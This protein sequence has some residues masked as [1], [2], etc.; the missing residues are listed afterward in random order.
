MIL[1][2]KP[3]FAHLFQ[4]VFIMPLPKELVHNEKHA[5]AILI[6]IGAHVY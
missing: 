5:K 3:I 2:S 1:V 4:Q 6:D